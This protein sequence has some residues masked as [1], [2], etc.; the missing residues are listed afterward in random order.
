MVG[1][2]H[3]PS[4]NA[5]GGHGSGR[6]G[7][8]VGNAPAGVGADAP[9]EPNA[10]RR[11][12]RDCGLEIRG[13]GFD[14]ATVRNEPNLGHCGF[15]VA[16]WGFAVVEAR[17]DKRTQFGPGG[18]PNKPNLPL[19]WATNAGGVR[20]RSQFARVLTTPGNAKHEA[21]NTKQTRNAN[22]PNRR[23][24]KT[25]PIWSDRR[26]KQ[27][28]FR[29]EGRY[30]G[31]KVWD[32]GFEAAVAGSAKPNR[33]RRPARRGSAGDCAKQSQFAA[34]ALARR[35]R[36]RQTNPIR[37]VP[38]GA[39]RLCETNPIAAYGDDTTEPGRT[40]IRV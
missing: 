11:E 2:I 20:K 26:A 10:G 16:D 36:L 23:K 25:N 6:C 14:G 34:G 22:D 12:A 27:T 9:N 24:R 7:Q 37:P 13:Y 35:R 15:W 31:M 38:P 17:N 1:E 18:A 29:R 19:F 32:R 3:I 40:Q 5:H 39:T 33:F 30:W 4:H 8:F 21:Q 28:Q